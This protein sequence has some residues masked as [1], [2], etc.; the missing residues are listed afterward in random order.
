MGNILDEIVAHKEREVASLKAQQPEAD[1]LRLA[2]Q[3]PPARDFFGAVTRQ[4]QPDTTAVISEIK[5]KSPSAGWI[6][7]EYRPDGD[8]G[9]GFRPEDIARRYHRAGARAISCLTD[10][11][12]FGGRLS[13]I[14]R[15][16]SA[17]PLPVL[18]KDFLIDPWQI[19]ESRAAGADAVL[20]IAECLDDARLA[21]MLDLAV[22]LGMT[23]LLE[24]HDRSNLHR[25]QKLVPGPHRGRCLFGI[26]NRDLTSMTIDLG[27]T[28]E[29]VRDVPDPGVLVSESGIRTPADL[30]RL[31]LG[32]VR[33]V[34]VGE[35][36]M[37][38]P[39]PGT[40]LA[41]LLA[42]QAG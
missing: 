41:E 3:M 39:D 42:Q 24:S 4:T 8:S 25:L 32:G 37:A 14:E 15:V 26:N 5:R 40:A 12:F 22:G 7:D 31:R 18:R 23:A 2:E 20:L 6:R 9:D 10:E 34:L 28:L 13:Y 27:H 38:Q 30:H 29:L 35:H 16:R 33:I 17:V 36:L 19:F 1:L 11:Y 21:E